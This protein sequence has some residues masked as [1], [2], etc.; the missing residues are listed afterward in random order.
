M[1]FGEHCAHDPWVYK[2]HYCFLCGLE[3]PDVVVKVHPPTAG[4]G[5]LCIDGGGTR[6]ILPLQIMKLIQE[7][8]GSPIPVQRFFKVVLGIGSGERLVRCKMTHD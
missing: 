4:V 1:M 2:I 8:I 5:V 7:R 6:G 3:T